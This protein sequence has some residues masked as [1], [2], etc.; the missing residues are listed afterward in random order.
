LSELE[1]NSSASATANLSSDQIETVES[2]QAAA[3]DVVPAGPAFEHYL[4]PVAAFV[5]LPLF[6]LFNTGIVL[7]AGLAKALAHPAGLG[8]L[9]GL[10][11]GKQ[12][13]I[14]G[15]SWIVIRT[16]LAD[17][18]RGITWGQIYGVAILAGVGLTMALF[19]S[20]LAFDSERLMSYS[21]AGIMT[22]SAICAVVGYFVLRRS[23]DLK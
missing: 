16:G 19:V 18:P 6:A 10:V 9:L 22:A 8:V 13:G 15:A 20:D 5:V 23:L 14:M 21:R 17:M 4:H 2:L 11:L 12:A 1:A 3:R 7:D